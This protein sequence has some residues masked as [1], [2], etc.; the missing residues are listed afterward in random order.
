MGERKR[1][2]QNGSHGM[3]MRKK[4]YVVQ[5]GWSALATVWGMVWRRYLDV[6]TRKRRMEVALP[7]RRAA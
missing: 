3:G 1:N 2:G 6:S 5:V 4:R 7:V